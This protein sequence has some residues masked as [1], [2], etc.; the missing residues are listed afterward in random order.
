METIRD[1][2][3]ERQLVQEYMRPRRPSEARQEMTYGYVVKDAPWSQQYGQQQQQQPKKQAEYQAN[4]DSAS[5]FPSLGSKSSTSG[6][7]VWGPWGGQ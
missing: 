7:K 3:E 1:Q 6:K 4:V 5:D 2:I